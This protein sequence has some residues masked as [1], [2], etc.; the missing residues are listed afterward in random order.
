LRNRRRP[1]RAI[2]KEDQKMSLRQLPDLSALANPKGLE[3]DMDETALDRFNAGLRAAA[4]EASDTISIL[5]PIGDNY[6]T[7]GVTAKRIAAALRSI[8]AKPVDVIVNS[9]GG[10]L[11]EGF[12]IYN[13]LRDHKA[14]VTVKVI[15][16]AASAA[17]VIAMAGDTVLV[18]RAGFIMIHNAWGMVIGNRHDW[19]AAA[20]TVEPF[21]AAMAS[22][23]A[24]RTG[25][26]AKAIGKWMDAE[27]WFNGDDA[28]A[29]GFADEL[30]PADQV[31]E[32]ESETSAS[33]AVR[34]IESA[35]KAKG[36][37]RSQRRQVIAD[38]RQGRPE[39]GPKPPTPRAGTEQLRS[40]AADLAGF[41]GKLA[42]LRG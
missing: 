39:G 6:W 40:I 30:L 34:Q 17:S 20:D 33:A 36:L 7:E 31:R 2:P 21:D 23:Y 13:L 42:T 25:N 9:P 28:V 27:T 37:T 4:D 38:F 18:P 26:D 12:A 16:L 32:K 5:G 22:V 29:Q 14:T 19:R 11:F 3:W 15:G 41:A 35:L 1:N 24:A 8:G 10:D